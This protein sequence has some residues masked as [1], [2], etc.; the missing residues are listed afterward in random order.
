ME[1]LLIAAS[2][3]ATP[4]WDKSVAITISICC[5]IAL[6]LSLRISKPL[7]GPKL[8]ILPISIPT[9]IAAMCFGH[10]LGIGVVLGLANIGRF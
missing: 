4:E 7:V 10:I 2:V 1:T 3:P 8:P 5:I 9:F 6:L